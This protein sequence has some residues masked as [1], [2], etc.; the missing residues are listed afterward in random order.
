MLVISI[1]CKCILLA[2]VF[3]VVNNERFGISLIMC[4]KIVELTKTT[5]PLIED[6]FHITVTK[7]PYCLPVYKIG[8]LN[9]LTIIFK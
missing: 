8:V 1:V 6:E 4:C 3:T 9:T 5:V 2:S 7:V